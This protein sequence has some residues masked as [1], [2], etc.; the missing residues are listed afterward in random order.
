[1]AK[2]TPTALFLSLI[3]TG[4]VTAFSSVAAADTQCYRADQASGVLAFDGVTEGR[5]FDG[6]FED[7]S[8]RMCLTDQ[9]LST[10]TIEVVVETGSADTNSRDRDQTLQG[11]EFFWVNQFPQAQW[12]SQAIVPSSG[13]FSHLV[14]GTL[15]LKDI[16]QDQAVEMRLVTDEAGRSRLQGQAEIF[17]LDYNVGTGEFADTDFIENRVGVTFDLGLVAEDAR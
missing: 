7:F 3:L 5:G 11:E 8:V 4:T 12:S 17:R 15:K 6:E 10:A 1:M 14:Q 16:S 2:I 13:E 9:D